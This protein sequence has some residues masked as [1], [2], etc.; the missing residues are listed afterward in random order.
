MRIDAFSQISQAYGIKKTSPV[1]RAKSASGQ[2]KLE[3]SQFGRDYQ[4][5]RQAISDSPDIREDRVSALKE[6]IDTGNYDVSPS[7]FA[8]KLMQKYGESYF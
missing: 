7:D 2:D 8:R 3:I 1:S 6:K 5:A 4:V